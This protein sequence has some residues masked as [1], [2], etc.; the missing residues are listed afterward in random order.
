M[1][2]GFVLW[3]VVD[4]IWNLMW[5]DFLHSQEITGTYPSSRCSVVS[6][7]VVLSLF[8]KSYF[9]FEVGSG[10]PF[11]LTRQWHLLDLE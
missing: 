5:V 8:S 10:R 7:R 1:R 2:R 3:A 4:E 9:S 6:E 11:W